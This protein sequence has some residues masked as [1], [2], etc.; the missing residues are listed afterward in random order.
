MSSGWETMSES[1]IP[2]NASTSPTSSVPYASSELSV[3]SRYA[4]VT[5]IDDVVVQIF[6]I[7]NGAG[8]ITQNGQGFQR[9]DELY[10]AFL[11]TTLAAYGAV[12]KPS[13]ASIAR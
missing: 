11:N 2:S 13:A 12:A 10:R 8:S 6:A 3:P 5:P 1:T 7:I 9:L 4:S